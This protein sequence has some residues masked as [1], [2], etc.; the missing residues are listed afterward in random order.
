MGP[1]SD[2]WTCR[3]KIVE[4][5]R[6]AVSEATVKALLGNYSSTRDNTAVAITLVGSNV[7]I[8]NPPYNKTMPVADFVVILCNLELEQTLCSASMCTIDMAGGGTYRTCNGR[9][10]T[11]RS[12]V[13]TTSSTLQL[14]RSWTARCRKLCGPI[15][16]NGEMQQTRIHIFFSCVRVSEQSTTVV[17]IGWLSC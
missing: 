17:E 9:M 1:P 6:A 7:S 16:S 4:P 14:R 12:C 2:E 8:V 5:D 11:R 15:P 13:C 3:T 10:A